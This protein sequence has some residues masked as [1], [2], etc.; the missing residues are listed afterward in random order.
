[1]GKVFAADYAPP[2]PSNLITATNDVNTAYLDA[3]NR[4]NPDFVNL[5]AGAIGGLTLGRG[6]YK[7]TT[8]VTASSD[9]TI[10][11]FSKYQESSV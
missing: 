1:V 8:G 7:W 9:V 6:L 10:S 3:F 5:G 2:T 11:G 4:V